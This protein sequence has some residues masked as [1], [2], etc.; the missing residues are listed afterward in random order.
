MRKVFKKVVSAFSNKQNSKIVAGVMN[1]GKAASTMLAENEKI[2]QT[3]IGKRAIPAGY[4]SGGRRQGMLSKLKDGA[5]AAMG[6]VGNFSKSG[7]RA[8]ISNPYS[9][10]AQF[11]VGSTAMASIAVMN[12]GM[13]KMDEIM[14]SRYMRDSR[15]SS[16][17]LANSNVGKSMGNGAL[18]LGNH[19]G[20][21]LSLSRGRHG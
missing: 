16:Q 11:A 19:T 17:M 2:L 1:R 21:S 3:S 8:L 5:T 14:T 4:L 20:L 6:T 12:G 15:Y 7:A 10:T 18:N 13:Q 9:M